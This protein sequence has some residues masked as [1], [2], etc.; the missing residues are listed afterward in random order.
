MFVFVQSGT[1]RYEVPVRPSSFVAELKANYLASCTF[2]GS[3]NAINLEYRGVRLDDYAKLRDYRI[4]AGEVIVH[5]PS[6]GAPSS[7]VDYIAL[8]RDLRKRERDARG[9][10]GESVDFDRRDIWASMTSASGMQRER[11]RRQRG[12]RA[13]AKR[14]ESTSLVP[15]GPRGIMQRGGG[16]SSTRRGS[17]KFTGNGSGFGRTYRN[18][19]VSQVGRYQFKT[20]HRMEGRWNGEAEL[21]EGSR[22]SGAAEPQRMRVVAVQLYFDDEYQ[23]WQEEQTF[24]MQ[25]GV[26]S[27][28]SFSLFPVA[29]GLL[30]VYSDS[31][32]D[33]VDVELKEDSENVLI[34]TAI[35]R[36][37][38]RPMNVETITLVDDFRRVRTV[39]RFTEDGEFDSLYIIRENRVVDSMNGAL[40]V[41]PVER[42]SSAAARI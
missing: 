19:T 26:A 38:K 23:R 6:S 15:Y 40:V 30:S 12:Y 37:T 29:D 22:S 25:D 4:Q 5:L 39:Q 10:A 11:L 34:L 24:T 7:T 18:M 27:T 32:P 2:P 9:G 36:V 28:Q 3:P 13:G 33:D 8:A 20:L 14:G 17:S 16:S 42:R 41:E 1:Q 21:V 31:F 35:S